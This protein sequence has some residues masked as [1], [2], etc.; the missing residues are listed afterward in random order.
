MFVFLEPTVRRC[1]PPPLTPI[2]PHPNPPPARLQV[3]HRVISEDEERRAV[4]ERLAR[5]HRHAV[6]KCGA[7]RRSNIARR[8]PSLRR[9][10]RIRGLHSTRRGRGRRARASN[11]R[12]RGRG[13]VT[14]APA[15]VR[16]RADFRRRRLLLRLPSAR[17]RWGGCRRSG[18]RGRFVHDEVAARPARRRGRCSPRRRI[19]TRRGEGRAHGSKRLRPQERTRRLINHWLVAIATRSAGTFSRDANTSMRPSVIMCT[20]SPSP[21]CCRSEPSA[22]CVTEDPSSKVRKLSCM[23]DGSRAFVRPMLTARATRSAP[24]WQGLQASHRRS[25]VLSGRN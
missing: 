17:R 2:G 12:A 24:P 5:E 9:G 15:K 23:R 7:R 22:N 3:Q 18:S 10:A 16:H 25:E 4:W 20:H 6:D 13:E 14:S 11:P 8:R 1:A 21:F 19:G